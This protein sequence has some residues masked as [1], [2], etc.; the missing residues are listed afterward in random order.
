MKDYS[1]LS[2]REAAEHISAL[3]PMNIVEAL[4]LE[5]LP[6]ILRLELQIMSALD[7][8]TAAAAAK[9]AALSTEV[10]VLNSKVDALI[11][12][13]QGAGVSQAQIDA[14][15]A[16]GAAADSANSALAAEAAK[17]DSANPPA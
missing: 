7:D 3:S 11:A 5:I 6:F 17:V 9:L 16:L 8:A 15:T 2:Y 1:K 13:A 10:G 12:L 4:L 14:V